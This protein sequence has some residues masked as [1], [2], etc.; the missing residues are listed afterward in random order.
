MLS[1]Q[2]LSCCFLGSSPLLQQGEEHFSAPKNAHDY[3]CALAL[4]SNS[5]VCAATGNFRSDH[6]PQNISPAGERHL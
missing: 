5:G 3:R 1:I 4:G 6:L 2:P